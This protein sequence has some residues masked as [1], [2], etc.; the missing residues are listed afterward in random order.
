MKKKKGKKAHQD[1][2]TSFVDTIQFDR[3]S[4]VFISFVA[5]LLYYQTL[6]YPFHFD[7]FPNII[8][9]PYIRN[10]KDFSL[11][12]KG[13]K[14]QQTWF[15]ALP[16]FTFA[17]NYHFHRFEV[18]GYHIFN[19]ILHICSG[20]L[21]Y[22]ISKHLFTFEFDKGGGHSGDRIHVFTRYKN[23]FLSLFVATIFIAHPIQVNTVTYIVQ[24]SEGLS[25]FF[26]LLSFFL[27]I[28]G[29]ITKGLSKAFYLIGMLFALL[30]SIFSKEIGF[31]LPI[32]L[33]LF[34][35]IFI[36]TG[37]EDLLKRFKIYGLPFIIIAIY[38]L[39]FLHGG[40]LRQLIK[41]SEAWYW[42]PIENLMTQANVIIQYI[43]LLFLPWPGWLN[44]D[45][46]FRVSKSLFEFPTFLSISIIL[47][48]LILATFLIKKKRLFSFAIYW[49]FIILAPTSSLIPIWDIMV[50]YRLYLPI[51]SYG[52]I[53][54]LIIHYLYHFLVHRRSERFSQ[55]ATIG[56]M[57][58]VLCVYSVFAI[59][60]NNVFKDSVGLWEDAIKKSPHKARA[61]H[62]LG[63]MLQRSNRLEEA[64]ETLEAALT[65][66]P[67]D[68]PLVHYNLGVVYSDFG[69]YEEAISHLGRYLKVSS[70][71]A[72]AHHEMGV[73]YLRMG[74]LE[75]ANFY[76]QKALEI[77][78]D[79]A[80]AHG[81][82]GDLYE[83]KGMI[84]E[85]IAEYQKAIRIDP[86]LAKT[87]VRLGEAYLKK[88][89]LKEALVEL[90]GAMTIDPSLPETYI[91]L[92]ALCLE[93]GEL[94]E[95][96]KFLK[97]ALALDSKN[98]EVYNN[99]GVGYRKKGKIDE[100]IV[101]YQKAIEIDPN[102]FDAHIN[103]G[104]AYWTKKWV[105]EAV[106]EYRKAL[107]IHPDRAEVYNNLGVIYLWKKRSDDAISYFKKALLLNPKYGEA[108]FNLAVVYYHKRD[109]RKAVDYSRQALNLGYRVDPKFL[110]LLKSGR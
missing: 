11:F 75:K 7:D 13:I 48:L 45:H 1:K 89:M 95:G 56:M 29:N 32:L 97:K 9:N 69:N 90:R 101:H 73:A 109:Y 19:L 94:E 64:R 10:L 100:A 74:S 87:R 52:L 49:F 25:S 40:I 81:S 76:L 37:K 20:I 71:D 78:P 65:K 41:G 59:Q 46:D 51:F 67:K 17:V 53:L 27:F 110:E 105:E 18:F 44:I 28:K 38:I 92:G 47:S 58:L 106:S 62:N 42:S 57:I 55:G 2:S 23:H 83:K 104:E 36:C 85:A 6:N 3:L 70:N 88:G 35:L 54:A 61:Y 79:F 31:T 66:N 108:C 84:Q 39:F 30:G 63:V 15:R 33:I 24:R 68:N 86:G 4:V 99:L 80:P 50:E 60:R 12:L 5:L 34:D 16:T 91:S 21:V 77:K 98:P 103:L 43:K 22:F 8:E 14:V 26:F 102:L 72:G 96:F 107:A 93:E 82:L